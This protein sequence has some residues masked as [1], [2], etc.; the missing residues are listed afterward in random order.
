MSY[1]I[2]IGNG[3][4]ESMGGSVW[5]MWLVTWSQMLLPMDN[6]RIPDM[7]QANVVQKLLKSNILRSFFDVQF[8][9]YL[10]RLL[11]KT[12]NS[13]GGWAPPTEFSQTNWI[14]SVLLADISEWSVGAPWSARIA[15]GRS[16]LLVAPIMWPCERTKVIAADL[17]SHRRTTAVL[18]SLS[19]SVLVALLTLKIYRHSVSIFFLLI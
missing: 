14:Q 3:R 9:T 4:F 6:G 10:R 15:S 2:P 11:V 13:N 17:A 1:I 18:S 16:W 7:V 12:S 19:M 5:V 8:Y